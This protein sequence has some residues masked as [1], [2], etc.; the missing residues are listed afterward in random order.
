MQPKRQQSNNRSKRNV[1]MNQ[2]APKLRYVETYKQITNYQSD[3]DLHI[4]TTAST[5]SYGL[6]FVTSFSVSFYINKAKSFL[7]VLNTST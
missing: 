7:S 2:K 3:G 6:S 4:F 1:S 5:Q